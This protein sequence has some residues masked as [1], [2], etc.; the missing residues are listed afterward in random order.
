MRGEESVGVSLPDPSSTDPLERAAAHAGLGLPMPRKV[1]LR[2]LKLIVARLTWLTNRHQYDYNQGVIEAIEQ[3][4]RD[5]AARPSTFN[6]AEHTEKHTADLTADYNR[7]IALAAATLVGEF[8]L[9]LKAMTAGYATDLAAL[10]A[11]LRS[12]LAATLIRSASQDGPIATAA[13]VAATATAATHELRG[14]I[15]G[16]LN[17][18]VQRF[19]RLEAAQVRAEARARVALTGEALSVARPPDGTHGDVFGGLDRARFAA[20]FRGSSEMIAARQSALVDHVVGAAGL[21]VDLGSGRGEWLRLLRDKGLIAIGVD[22]DAVSV[23]A[24]RDEGLDV[25]HADALAYLQGAAEA[26]V[27][28]ISA[29][30]VVEHMPFATM[31]E[32]LRQALRVLAPGGRILVETP[33]ITNLHTG[34]ANFHLDPSHVQPLHPLLL[35]FALHEV[36][37]AEVDVQL[38]HP[39]PALEVPPAAS[40]QLA[41]LIDSVNHALNCGQDTLATAVRPRHA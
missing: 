20:R 35:E 32:L 2:W 40:A 3:L 34:A 36:G 30:H 18:F 11:A 8:T 23:Q 37:F 19:D 13:A 29:L 27:A 31:V 9:Q 28:A 14:D 26:S 15:D 12:E 22:D 21:I 33:N 39:R 5:L 7:A 38:L 41:L 6:L 25:V 4:R 1:R 10:E 24:L 17:E 16:R